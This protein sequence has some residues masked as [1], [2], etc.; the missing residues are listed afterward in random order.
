MG[1]VP[2]SVSVSG[3]P[4]GLIGRDVLSRTV[5][6]NGAEMIAG[7]EL[8]FRR[9]SRLDTMNCAPLIHGD[10][11]IRLIH[12]QNKS[13][14]SRGRRQ[15]S[16]FCCSSNSMRRLTASGFSMIVP[17]AAGDIDG[18]R[19]LKDPFGISET[20][21]P[22]WIVNMKRRSDWLADSSRF[23]DLHLEIGFVPEVSQQTLCGATEGSAF[24]EA[25]DPD[26]VGRLPG[27]CPELF[28]P[29]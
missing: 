15:K 20:S 16:L 6:G 25:L 5:N 13:G 12:I 7:E 14:N 11:E 4:C 17:G 26:F 28:A 19:A 18:V 24:R 23:A 10:L 1:K 9:N 29:S 8:V 3:R 27:L 22:G 2:V 21:F